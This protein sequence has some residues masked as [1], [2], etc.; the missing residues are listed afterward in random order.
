MFRILSFK[1]YI[2]IILFK[3]LFSFFFFFDNKIRI[4]RK[5]K[6]NQ[7]TLYSLIIDDKYRTRVAIFIFPHVHKF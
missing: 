5:N 1:K 2:Y 4:S 3:D 6:K 7:N